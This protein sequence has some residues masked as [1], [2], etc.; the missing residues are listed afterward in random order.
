MRRQAGG[1]IG[2]VIGG[3]GLGAGLGGA[4]FP[5]PLL[6]SLLERWVGEESVKGEMKEKDQT[7]KITFL[8]RY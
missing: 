7:L 2:P 4:A 8:I 5:P 3:G 1:L 6:P